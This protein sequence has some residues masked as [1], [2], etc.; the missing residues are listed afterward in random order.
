LKIIPVLA[1]MCYVDK[2]K[3]GRTD[4]LKKLIGDF[5]SFAKASK[6]Y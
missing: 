6:N 1:R 2:E 4:D 5:C 3:D